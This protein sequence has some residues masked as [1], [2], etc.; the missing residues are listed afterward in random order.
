MLASFLRLSFII[1]LLF[2]NFLLINKTKSTTKISEKKIDPII[3]VII[4]YPIVLGFVLYFISPKVQFVSGMMKD[5]MLRFY[6]MEHVLMMVIAIVLI[7]IGYS[8][9]RPVF[10]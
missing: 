1:N 4:E 10:N 2:L 7:T 5:S 6:G 3:I 8:D 9:Y